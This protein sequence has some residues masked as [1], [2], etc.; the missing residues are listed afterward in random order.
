VLTGF[1]CH[2]GSSLGAAEVLLLLLQLAQAAGH[3]QALS[4]PSCNPVLAVAQAA[5]LSL[6]ASP[7]SIK[8]SELVSP[9]FLSQATL[10][11]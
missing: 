1:S 2:P 6:C 11:S 3:T 5:Q 8:I 9:G 7:R 10:I 4:L